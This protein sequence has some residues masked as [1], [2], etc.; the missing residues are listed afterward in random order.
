MAIPALAAA[1]RALGSAAARMGASSKSSA[2]LVDYFTLEA[3]LGKSVAP[4]FQKMKGWFESLQVNMKNLGITI[5]FVDRAIMA[6]KRG[7]DTFSEAVGATRVSELALEFGRHAKY[8]GMRFDQFQAL[9]MVTEH[10]GATVND[11]T[12]MLGTMEQKIGDLA[13]S[14]SL[15]QAL[16]GTGLTANTFKGLGTFERLLVLQEALTR[17]PQDKKVRAFSILGGDDLSRKFGPLGGIDS[18]ISQMKE[19]MTLGAVLSNQQASSAEKYARQQERLK[20]VWT[21]LGNNIASIFIPGL[22]RFSKSLE[23]L[24]GGISK[25]VQDK[26]AGWANRFDTFVAKMLAAFS[27]IGDAMARIMPIDEFFARATQ[28]AVAFV[29]ILTA[30]LHI[31]SILK[32]T[33]LIKFLA[34]AV[35]WSEDILVFLRGG[36]SIIGEFFQQSPAMKKFA[37]VFAFLWESIKLLFSGMRSL[38]DAFFQMELGQDVLALMVVALSSMFAIAGSTATALT[39]VFKTISNI[40]SVIKAIVTLLLNMA[41]M[42]FTMLSLPFA[43]QG[44]SNMIKSEGQSIFDAIYGFARLADPGAWL[45]TNMYSAGPGPVTTGLGGAWGAFNAT[46]PQNNVVTNHFTINATGVD[47]SVA[48]E[49]ALDTSAK[50]ALGSV[51]GKTK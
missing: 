50:I 30:I 37:G 10:Y 1:G 7:W 28:G 46:S 45:P 49:S 12:D 4:T 27:K 22:T 6:L 21:G 38:A 11:V 14:K 15:Q 33:S 43:P 29:G 5:I 44:A 40:Y 26:S 2:A 47:P 25:Y 41:A 8:Y 17:L 36:K 31:A 13:T 3:D 34:Y 51:P 24:I 9:T 16:A 32:F 48:M 42:P 19:L 18:I 23:W 39:I 20:A 35:L